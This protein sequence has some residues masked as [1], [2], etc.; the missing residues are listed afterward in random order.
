MKL[1]KAEDRAEKLQ[2]ALDAYKEREQ[3]RVLKELEAG[4]DALSKQLKIDKDALKGKNIEFIRGALFV[5]EHY[6]KRPISK[7]KIIESDSDE[8][9]QVELGMDN[10]IWDGEGWF[11]LAH[12]KRVKI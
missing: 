7:A 10:L 5:A 4:M 1:A 8:E 6:N 2:K 12:N 9:L 3:E 11:D